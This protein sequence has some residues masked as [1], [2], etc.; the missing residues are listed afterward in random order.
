MKR[1]QLFADSDYS[2]DDDLALVPKNTSFSQNLRD[3]VVEVGNMMTDKESFKRKV[4]LDSSDLE[5]AN[6][7]RSKRRL[8][9]D[10]FDEEVTTEN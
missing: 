7:R 5:E 6:S 10:S 4:I 8:L 9:L 3:C 2:D 1:S